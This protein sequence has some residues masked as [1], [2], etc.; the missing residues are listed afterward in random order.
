L[1]FCGLNDPLK[2]IE[3]MGRVRLENVTGKLTALVESK[4]ASIFDRLS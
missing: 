3:T 1:E 4:R 2:N